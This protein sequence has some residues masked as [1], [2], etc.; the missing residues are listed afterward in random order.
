MLGISNFIK[1]SIDKSDWLKILSLVDSIDMAPAIELPSYPVVTSNS[2]NELK[3][4]YEEI[5]IKSLQGFLF[6]CGDVSFCGSTDQFLR[7]IYYVENARDI[8]EQLEVEYLIFGSP[9]L[10]RRGLDKDILFE[11][12]K[13]LD[14]LFNGT[15]VKFIF[16]PASKKLGSEVVNR[17]QD[18]LSLINLLKLKNFKVILDYMN[19][20]HT[21]ADFEALLDRGEYDHVHINAENYAFH[22]STLEELLEQCADKV[23]ALKLCINIEIQP[24]SRSQVPNLL[25]LLAHARS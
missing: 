20:V 21:G 6:N 12:L 8:A 19:C 18:Q 9:G 3:K 10:R 17:Y 23:S 11:R 4:Q 13:K 2:I 14:D 5:K 7:F 22:Y 16:E 25:K 1:K 24:F 15:S